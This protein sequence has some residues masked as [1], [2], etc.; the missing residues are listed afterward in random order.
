MAAILKKILV[1][2]YPKLISIWWSTTQVSLMLLTQNPQCF[3]HSA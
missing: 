2:P 1:A 3:H